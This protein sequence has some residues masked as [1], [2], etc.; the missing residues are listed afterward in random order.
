METALVA[1]SA[2]SFF[3]MLPRTQSGAV[4]LSS[5]PV[6]IFHRHMGEVA[7]HVSHAETEN[8]DHKARKRT[9]FVTVTDQQWHNMLHKHLATCL[10][11]WVDACFPR[12]TMEVKIQIYALEKS[13]D[14]EMKSQREEIKEWKGR[15]V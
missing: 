10:N 1:I 7:E 4:L 3:Q 8:N 12:N 15:K 13:C 5:Q 14:H 11:T 2:V 9:S 6:F